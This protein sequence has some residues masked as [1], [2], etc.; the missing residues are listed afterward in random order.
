MLS[1]GRLQIIPDSPDIVLHGALRE[2][3]ST[4]L[5]GR[6]IL[7]SKTPRA[8]SSLVVRFRPKDEDMLN[9]AMSVAF[10]PEIACVVIKDGQVGE[11]S[12]EVLH[13]MASGQQAWRFSIGIPGN[14]NET[15][16]SPS[17]FI[18]YELVAE[19]RIATGVAAWAPFSKL[20]GSTPLAVKRVPASDSAWATMASEAMN[21]SAV[22]RNRI[23]L[24][25]ITAS[26]V[27]H[28]SQGIRV[29]GVL[30]PQRKGMRLLRAGFELREF[31]NGPFD[32]ASAN[33]GPRAHTAARCARD[34]NATLPNAAENSSG[35]QIRM[36][37]P[38]RSV[39]QRAGVVIDQDIQVTGCL[40]LPPAYDGLQYDVPIGP[41]RITH[42]LAFTASVVDECGQVHNVRLSSRVYVFPQAILGLSD[43]PRYENSDKD[44]LLAAGRPWSL[45]S[46]ASSDAF[47][48]PAYTWCPH[49]HLLDT[50]LPPPPE[51]RLH[52]AEAISGMPSFIQNRSA[53]GS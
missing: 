2:A 42:E 6:V 21:V 32:S 22:W 14:I 25:S 51:Y 7:T 41:I 28:D 26:R 47:D 37:F 1:K 12:A 16:F 17:A 13:D 8:I 46:D 39:E 31:V 29:S 19:L 49:S 4:M 38:A 5:S 36:E 50:L 33:S 40:K 10:M 18:A 43:L 48:A 24:T 15:V 27:V 34:I 45:A 53:S 30:R 3:R 52:T 11:T 35:V 44:V 9:P 20:V 23:E